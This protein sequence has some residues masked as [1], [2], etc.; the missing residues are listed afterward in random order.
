MQNL[1]LYYPFIHF[2]NESWLK[3]TSLYWDRMSRIV[4]EGYKLRDTETVR[5]FKD[6]GYIIDYSPSGTDRQLMRA[7]RSLL[8]T[9]GER[10]AS[11]Y[12]LHLSADWPEE[13]SGA[14][15]F[16]DTR[17]AYIFGLEI[18][19]DLVDELVALNLAERGRTRDPRWV[20]MHPR[21]AGIYMTALADAM[22]TRRGAEP[23]SDDALSHIGI[24]D[25]SMEGLAEALLAEDDELSP[26][27]HHGAEQ[28]VA[29]LTIKLVVPANLDNV[30][31][32]RLLDFRARYKAERAAFQQQVR[33]MVS[34][35]R[36][37]G[38]EDPQA[39]HDHLQIQYEKFLEPQLADLERRLRDAKI[40]TVSAVLNVKTSLPAQTVGAGLFAHA[41]APLIATATV[42]LGVWQV[43]R[44]HRQAQRQVLQERPAAAYLYRLERDLGPKALA[45]R[46][47]QLSRM[48]GRRG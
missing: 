30:E 25:F 42:A 34:E 9:H 45:S 24:S 6:H 39:L 43:W 41:P 22:A 15:H 28:L 33:D 31:P 1:G 10:L 48:F 44:D 35:L 12:G 38:I 32:R 4:P 20:G 17:L 21:L 23:V 37:G 7:F 13:P 36:G 18:D 2:R 5:A 8:A 40:D 3:M 29:S 11:R 14:G 16:G 26:P 27:L 19:P 47:N 46:I